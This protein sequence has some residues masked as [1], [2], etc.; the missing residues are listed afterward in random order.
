MASRASLEVFR[1][2]EEGTRDYSSDP[3][4]I[5][6]TPRDAADFVEPLG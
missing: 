1:F 5:R 3:I 6:Q 4:S 2:P